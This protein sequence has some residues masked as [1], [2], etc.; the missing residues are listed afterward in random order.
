MSDRCVAITD[1]GDRCSRIGAY[2]LYDKIYC[3]QHYYM[4]LEEKGITKKLKGMPP[5]QTLFQMAQRAQ[6]KESISSGLPT[7]IIL[8]IAEYQDFYDLY[9]MIVAYPAY[10]NVLMPLLQSR[11]PEIDDELVHWAS[12]YAASPVAKRINKILFPRQW[13]I[14]D[15]SSG[16]VEFFNSKDEAVAYYTRPSGPDEELVKLNAKR[17]RQKQFSAGDMGTTFVNFYI[18]RLY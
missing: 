17:L 4:L 18:R 12:L 1:S 2:T 13:V 14:F 6:S 7:E 3:R 5:A 8:K 10:F 16:E 9:N 15:H 11:V